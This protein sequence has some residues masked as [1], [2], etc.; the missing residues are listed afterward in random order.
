MKLK[1]RSV[2]RAINKLLARLITEQSENNHF[3][4]DKG[5]VTAVVRELY[6]IYKFISINLKI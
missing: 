1:A 2:K 3:K 4:D 6:T 5:C